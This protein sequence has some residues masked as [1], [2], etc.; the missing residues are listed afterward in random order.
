MSYL[1]L[2]GKKGLNKKYPRSADKTCFIL[3]LDTKS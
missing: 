1:Y 2:G 3:Y